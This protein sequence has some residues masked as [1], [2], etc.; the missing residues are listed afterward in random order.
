MEAFSAVPPPSPPL[1]PSRRKCR[2]FARRCERLCC[3][4]CTY[5]P[6]A[7]VYGLTT[8][9]VYVEARMGM[10]PAKSRWIGPWTSA[11]GIILYFLLNTSYTMA[12]FTDPGS[13]LTGPRTNGRG[14]RHDYSSLPTTETP[15][16]TSLTVSS[17]GGKRYFS[18][19]WVWTEILNNTRYIDSFGPVANIL[20]AIIA[21]V[22]GLVLSAFTA[23]HIS[24]AA[25]G[26]TTIECL[27]KT[28]YLAPIRKSFDRQRHERARQVNGHMEHTLGHTLQNYGHQLLDAHANAIPGVT[29]AEEGE[30]RSSPTVPQRQFDPERAQPYFQN[31]NLSPAQ[32]SLYHSYEELEHARERARYDEYLDEQDG[33]KLPHAFDLG[34]CRNLRH[35]FG[36]N[37]LFWLLP[38]CN[39]TGDGWHWEASAKWLEMKQRIEDRRMQR[40]REHQPQHQQHPIALLQRP[41]T[42]SEICQSSGST[43]AGGG[44][45]DTTRHAADNQAVG[46]RGT[47]VQR[48]GTGLSMK[49]LRPMS[50][51]PRPGEVTSEDDSTPGSQRSELYEL[52]R[53][54]GGGPDEWGDWD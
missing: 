38:I 50:P 32:Q 5:S 18:A 28:R 53:S 42:R 6:L 40:W 7:F 19:T 33:E 29:R 45:S 23:W 36:T 20:L 4:L 43:R 41:S 52:G 22:I 46:G 44:Y 25:R 9:S 37:P 24:L 39:T 51:R 8:W 49:T 2:D 16:C 11:L 3:N 12:V 21:G 14:N 30:E 35:L 34:W 17:T 10:E 15:E 1:S 13:P 31:Q 26:M 54:R 48:P 47:D 27:E